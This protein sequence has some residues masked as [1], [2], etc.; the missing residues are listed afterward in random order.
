MHFVLFLLLSLIFLYVFHHCESIHSPPNNR[1]SDTTKNQTF[2]SI[3][4]QFIHPSKHYLSPTTKRNLFCFIY[5]AVPT[6]TNKNF[7]KKTLT[8]T[9]KT[10]T[11]LLCGFIL[12]PLLMIMLRCFH[13]IRT[14]HPCS[15]F[16][17]IAQ[18]IYGRIFCND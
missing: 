9:K 2:L 18:S 5:F 6:T 7:P 1:P 8:I 14:N 16:I 3:I 15:P 10:K 17:L 4:R 12:M 13:Y 11:M